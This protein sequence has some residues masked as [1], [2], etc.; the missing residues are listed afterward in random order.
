MKKKAV[1]VIPV[2][3]EELTEFEI[4]SLQQACLIF[5]KYTFCVIT[6]K[7][8]K[9][10]NF[11]AILNENRIQFKIV[12]FSENSFSNIEKYSRLM[13]SVVFYGRFIAYEYILIYQLDCFAFRDELDAWIKTGY[14][15]IGAPWMDGYDLAS[16]G[17]AVIGVGNGGFSL[18]KVSAHLRVL[19]SF[20]KID[21]DHLFVVDRNFFKRILLNNTFFILND[22]QLNEDIFWGVISKRNFPWFKVPEW[23]LAARFSV[24]VQ[25]QYFFELNNYTLPFGCHAWWRY[26][27][28]F[29]KPHIEQFG[30][31]L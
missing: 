14:S 4:I 21:K 27:L 1:I 20:S 13:L 5:K 11:L 23:E 10:D 3:K 12:L 22:F 18:R 29:W 17:N 15:Y 31:K 25:P 19:L 28:E 2:W 6:F 30:Y 9:L 24:E 8:L 16:Y 7:H 26:D